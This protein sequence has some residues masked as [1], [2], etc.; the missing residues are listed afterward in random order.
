MFLGI[1]LKYK[2]NRI[3]LML[4][5]QMDQDTL[6][7]LVRQIRREG[8]DSVLSNENLMTPNEALESLV[9]DEESAELDDVTGRDC[10]YSNTCSGTNTSLYLP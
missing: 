4:N 2:K 3:E 10:Q 5:T 9:F 1:I 6:M 7:G 8:I